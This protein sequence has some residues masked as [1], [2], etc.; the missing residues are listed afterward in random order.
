[1]SRGLQLLTSKIAILEDLADRTDKQVQQLTDLL[2]QRSRGLQTKIFEGEKLIRELDQSMQRSKEVA[3]IFQDR[4]PH[5]EIIER[6]NTIR[7]VKAAQMAHKGSS[8]EEIATQ[9]DLPREQIEFIAKVNK[10]QLMFDV[11]QLPEWA[12]PHLDGSTRGTGSAT[13]LSIGPVIAES[14]LSKPEATGQFDEAF[15]E[16]R[17]SAG[18]VETSMDQWMSGAASEILQQQKKEAQ[19]R[20]ENQVA[21]TQPPVSPNPPVRTVRFPR[22]DSN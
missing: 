18:F 14:S 3:E 8:I 10:K 13:T 12:K 5:E 15:S 16:S 9:V 1:M 2:E 7:Y 17:I 19:A 22:I 4:I 20:S 21:T 11:S 6:Q